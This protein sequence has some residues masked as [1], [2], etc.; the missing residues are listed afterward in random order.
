MKE[1]TEPDN[2][3]NSLTLWIHVNKSVSITNQLL[4]VNNTKNKEVIVVVG[5]TL[6]SYFKTSRYAKLNDMWQCTYTG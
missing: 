4:Y 1:K 5:I 3:H 6:F 2:F